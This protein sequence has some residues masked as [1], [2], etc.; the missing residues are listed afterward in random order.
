MPRLHRKP[1]FRRGWT[2]GHLIQLLCGHDWFGGWG[3]LEDLPAVE[4]VAAVDDMAACWH[5]HRDE[6][7]PENFGLNHEGEPWF[8]DYAY[9][10]QRLINE[11]R[12]YRRHMYVFPHGT[13]CRCQ[14]CVASE[15]R[16]CSPHCTI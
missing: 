12:G 3:R 4:L 13:A 8:A 16:V 9:D 14:N 2:E 5:A 6:V 7:T 10:S 15:P 11:C 1:K